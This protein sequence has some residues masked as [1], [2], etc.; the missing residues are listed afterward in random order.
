MCVRSFCRFAVPVFFCISG[1]FLTKPGQFEAKK[2][3]SKAR[4]IGGILIYSSIFYALFSLVWYPL[5]YKNWD[6]ATF[7]AQTFCADKIVQYFIVNAPFLYAHL[8]FLLGLLSC[9]LFCMFFYTNKNYKLL[10]YIIFPISI[11]G[12]YSMQEFNYFQS[13]VE[14]VGL[15]K[16]LMLYNLFFF[17]ALP[18]FLLGTILRNYQETLIQIKIPNSILLTLSVAGCC[19]AVGERFALRESQFYIGSAITCLSM[20]CLAIRNPQS[21]SPILVHIGRDLSLYIYILHIA[22][23][24]IGDLMGKEFHWWGHLP[25][26]IIRPFAILLITILLSEALYRCCKHA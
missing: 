12:Y 8:W 5:F 13:Y 23:G 22:V 4:H 14:L 9:Y 11:V 2:M 15:N 18:F 19:L 20:M 16:P 25:Y 26:Y 10:T 7:C 6:I 17:R 1:F 24:K 3:V 21:G